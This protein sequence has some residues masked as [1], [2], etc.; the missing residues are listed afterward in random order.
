MR[1][2]GGREVSLIP[3]EG[4]CFRSLVITGLSPFCV[5]G[6][7]DLSGRSP[8]ADGV[9]IG[10]STGESLSPAFRSWSGKVSDRLPNAR[11]C[12][13]ASSPSLC[14]GP[15]PPYP[16]FRGILGNAILPLLPE[17]LEAAVPGRSI[18][19]PSRETSSLESALSSLLDVLGNAFFLVERVRATSKGPGAMLFILVKRFVACLLGLVPYA[20]SPSS[21]SDSAKNPP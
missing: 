10:P 7:L 15:N 5:D 19:D 16:F 8:G 13:L 18:D 21:D 11:G 9:R 1:G 17:E 2:G 14:G 20:A 3:Y 12:G 4:L 6:L